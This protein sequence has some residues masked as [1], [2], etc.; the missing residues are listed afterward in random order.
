MSPVSVG[1]VGGGEHARMSLLPSLRHALGGAPDGLP[2]LV[3]THSGAQLPPLLGEVVALAEHKQDHAQRI[4]ALHG[5]PRI[6]ANHEE[7]LAQEKLDCVIV[8]LH[9]RLQPDV[10]IACLD[11]GAHVLLEKPQAENVTDS[12]RIRDAARRNG[13][14]VAV[15]FMKRFSAPYLRARQIMELPAFGQPSMYEARFTYARYPVDVYNFLNGFGIHHLDLP[16]FFMG[17]VDTVSAECVSRGTGLDGYAITLR[18]VSGAL[19]LINI[20][21][22]ESNFTNWSERLSISGVGSSLHVENWRRVIAFVAGE[23]EMRYWEPEDI[24]PTDAA[25]SLNLH[26]FV[27]EV[28]DFVT[29]VATNS[30]SRSTLQDGIESVRLQEAIELSVASGRRVELKEIRQ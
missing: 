13:K 25:N 23:Q 21:C 30:V 29:S 19:G 9:P 27:G 7:M 15:A 11:A 8:C 17:D 22:L 18:F 6:Y 28:Q 14:Q 20:N 10:A 2:A 5:I 24:Q 1:F 4:A 16:R 3:A 12:L 26:G